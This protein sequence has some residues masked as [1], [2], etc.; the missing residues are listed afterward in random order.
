ML[1]LKNKAFDEWAKEEK[2]DDSVLIDAIEELQQGLYEAN[3]GGLVYK[4]RI[5]AKGKGKRAG[6]RTIVAYRD[7]RL[8]VFMYGYLKSEKIDLSKREKQ[9][10]KMLAEKYVQHNEDN[11]KSAIDSGKLVRVM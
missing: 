4:K 7:N 10:F 5:P 3:L 8:A 11:L 9:A 6:A 1:I 2:I